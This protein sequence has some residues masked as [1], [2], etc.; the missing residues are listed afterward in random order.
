MLS[1]YG[2]LSLAVLSLTALG[3][4]AVPQGAYAQDA[5]QDAKGD[6]D[7][8]ATDKQNQKIDLNVESANLYYALN[9]LFQH[10]KANFQLDPALKQLEVTAHFNQVPFRVALETLLKSSGQPLTYR[11]ENNIYS[12][13]PKIETATGPETPIGTEEKP[14]E[15]N[16]YNKPIKIRSDQLIYNAVDIVEYLGGKVLNAS[17]PTSQGGFGGGGLG[18]FGGGGFGGGGL[19]GGGFGGGGIGGGRGGG[20]GGF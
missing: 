12:V 1:R 6:T 11:F 15:G 13:V 19:G 4:V 5:K 16:K 7:T 20:R 8:S 9:L 14:A 18:G 10:I 3:L 2:K 17:N